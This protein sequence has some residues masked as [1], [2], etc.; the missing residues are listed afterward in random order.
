MEE[1]E[2]KR[3]KEGQVKIGDTCVYVDEK[4]I[5]HDALITAVWMGE[6]GVNQ[7]PGL[8]L[9]YISRDENRDDTYGRQIERETSVIHK[10]V[11]PAHGRY[12]YLR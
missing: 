1:A 2:V 10:G 9:V 7:F 5:P 11:Q 4:G 3:Y 8:N 6:F 12:W